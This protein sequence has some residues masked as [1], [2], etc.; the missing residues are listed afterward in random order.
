M[1]SQMIGGP[2]LT[3][4]EEKPAR[5][6]V[7]ALENLNRSQLSRAGGKAA[8]LGETIRAGLPVPGGFCVTTDA[9]AAVASLPEV[10]GLLDAV[11]SVAPDEASRLEELAAQ[12]RSAI[13]NAAVPEE[14]S[15]TIQDAYA[16]LGAP[17][18]HG[19][20]PVAVRSSAT[21]E[22]LPG[23]SFA[24]QQE[25]YLNVVGAEALIEAVRRCWASLWTDRAVAYRARAGVDPRGVRSAVVVQR[26]IESAVAGVMFT[27]NP[28]TGKRGQAVIDASPGLGE[29]VVSGAVTPDHFVVAFENGSVL[30]RRIG[31]K[32]LRIEPVPGGGTRR[33]DMPGDSV[34]ARPCLSDSQLR[35]LAQLAR[36]VERYYGEPQDTEWAI[37]AQGTLWL[38]QSRPI[39]TL[40]PLPARANPARQDLRAYF[41][42]NVAQG[43][44]APLTT[45]GIQAFRLLGSGVARL[46]GHPAHDTVTGPGLLVD[47]GH[48]L[49]FDVTPALRTPLGR[50]VLPFLLGHMEVRSGEQLRAFL[51][52]PRLAPRP[53]AGWTF[54]LRA[55][56]FLMRTG[57]L[58]RALR[59]LRDPDGAVEEAISRAESLR[60]YG[61]VDA[62]ASAA[63]RLNRFERLLSEGAPQVLP[64]VAPPAA[65]G[66]ACYGISQRLLRGL[67][68]AD[69]LQAVR[70]ALP[71][72]P[73][74]EMDLELWRLA[75]RIR[76]DPEGARAF[77]GQSAAALGAAYAAGALPQVVMDGVRQFLERYGQRGVG[78]I[79]LGEP[80][81]RDDPGQVLGMLAN[82][83]AVD[84]PSSGPEAQLSRMESE[85][86]E[87]VRELSRRAGRRNPV[88][89]AAVRFFLDRYRR[90]A[91]LREA[92]KYYVVLLFGE[93]R[94]L[95]DAIGAEL[96]E[97]GRLER[98][99]DV[100]Q[101]NVAELRVALNGGDVR[102]IVARRRAEAGIERQR[103]H[104][105]RWLL[106]DGSEPA[107]PAA[108]MGGANTLV[109]TAASL[110]VVT[111]TAR[112]ILDPRGARIEPGEILV[113][114]STDPGWTPLFLTA[115]GLVME[116]GGPMSHGAIVAR[117]YGIPAVV[118]LPEATERITTGQTVTLD[119]GAGTVVLGG[120]AT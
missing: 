34:T 38:L 73:T 106:S 107:P 70:R 14:I 90:L 96:A 100:Y 75:S 32:R 2:I 8:N 86:E 44:Y 55:A 69:E 62:G 112:V 109:G 11:A 63:E 49:F 115:G 88:A 84:D 43:V 94:K 51:D 25:T 74:T 64:A 111:A 67:A 102:P 54:P 119:G 41:S 5:A 9:Y 22:D 12:L 110:G 87:R 21:A 68:T 99:D 98:K 27:A 24:G 18:G 80:R 40:F 72:N 13:E 56:S 19:D 53:G 35:E 105:P 28:L 60:E 31:S 4:V 29:A 45:M 95:L 85:A 104:V 1:A 59:A 7:A 23:A 36:R 91:G 46:W 83:L 33:V 79:D 114:P 37:D 103:K 89:G 76:A 48:R 50:R 10:D 39:T 58:K 30:E 82:Y 26:Q 42:F 118:G 61:R 92:P 20:V 120:A 81:W 97:S 93:G 47:A 57:I 113:A 17:E 6:Y 52:D 117:E 66:F 3:R 16:A 77:V 71:H 101:L 15:R 78:E 65:M 108:P 116:M